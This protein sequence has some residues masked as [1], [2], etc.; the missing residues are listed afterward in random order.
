MQLYNND[1]IEPAEHLPSGYELQWNVWKILNR[2]RVGVGRSKNSL[3]KWGYLNDQ[4]AFCHHGTTQTMVHQLIF[5][6]TPGPGTLEN[7][8]AANQKAKDV[9]QF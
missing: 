8:T 9:A 1:W 2:L 3:L 5:P 6:L 4:N 7:L